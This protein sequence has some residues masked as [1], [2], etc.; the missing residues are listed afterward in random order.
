MLQAARRNPG[1]RQVS[2]TI[3]VPA[4]VAGWNRR[5]SVATMKPLDAIQL[6]N[7]FPTASDIVLR[8]GSA[9]HA[10]DIV[11][12]GQDEIR[13]ETLAVYRPQSGPQQMW[14]FADEYLFDV[15]GT[16]A[17]GVPELDS[18]TNARWQ[19]VNF[20]TAGG[21][22]ILAVN[23]ADEM[24]RYDGTNWLHL[25]GVSSPSIGGVASTALVNV[26]V[27]K[28]RP[29][30]VEIGSMS[31][32]YPDVGTFAGTLTEFSLDAVFKRG[33]YL[34]AMGT[35]T[36]DGGL[37][38][39]DFAVFI[40]S[41]GEVA[42]YQG[43][44]PGDT[45]WA[46]IGLYN[47]GSP[48]GRRC[49]VKYGGDLL[50]ITNDGVIPASKAFI[51]D[52]T[53]KA[54]AI[55]DKIQGAMSDS[56]ASYKLNEGWSLTQFPAG[57]MLILNIPV[58][59]DREEQYVMNSVTGAWC[60]FTGWAASCFEI[61]NDELYFG[62]LG[63]VH[64]AWSGTSDLTTQIV[65]EIIPAFSY[66]G[67]RTQLKQWSMFRPIVAVDVNP[68]QIRAGIDVDYVIKT[69]EST[70]DFPVIGGSLWDVA[71]WD[72]AVWG[73]LPTVQ[74]RWYSATAVGYCA[75]AHLKTT[76]SRSVIRLLAIDYVIC[77]GG[78]V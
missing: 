57:S 47:I 32:W 53:S 74:S 7:Y 52:R 70:I 10:T 2:R 25:N 29:Y 73:G 3:S 12:A 34:M 38:L 33:G 28:E 65:G 56:A 13:V 64:Q 66:F 9:E 37:G 61:F 75:A 42:V 19:Y 54:I 72:L 67:A 22:F 51:N 26:N 15:T 8:K 69:P 16:G 11:D 71:Q 55:T 59:P 24:L 77:D 23:G 45:A 39:D 6:D 31:A 78:V 1:R 35:W 68:E 27:F 62:T 49:C 60:R 58:A 40:S 21:Q 30:Y 48:I 36:V 46:L 63:G 4:P 50:I 44:Y 41:E 14:A 18:L 20:A 76:S 17:A 5:D 43:I